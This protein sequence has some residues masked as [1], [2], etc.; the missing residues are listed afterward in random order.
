MAQE[1]RHFVTLGMFIIDDF[2]YLHEDGSPAERASCSQVSNTLI[3]YQC[4]TT[5]LTSSVADWRRRNVRCDRCTDMVSKMRTI[6]IA[7][8][9]DIDNRGAKKGSR[10]QSLG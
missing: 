10:R 2:V 5:Y 9:E 4:G 8:E 3:H 6:L 1:K 7:E